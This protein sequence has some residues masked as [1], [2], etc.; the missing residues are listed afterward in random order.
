MFRV[1]VATSTVQTPPPYDAVAHMKHIYNN[2]PRCDCYEEEFYLNP[3]TFKLWCMH[4]THEWMISA[5]GYIS[6]SHNFKQTR[7]PG[8]Y[9]T[10]MLRDP[11]NAEFM[12]K[13]ASTI[14]DRLAFIGAL[15]GVSVA[16]DIVPDII[17]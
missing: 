13:K 6:L 4:K 7:A 3:L 2:R 10:D 11:S 5:P 1:N 16:P 14:E 17:I 9:Y 12:F 8:Y 15:S